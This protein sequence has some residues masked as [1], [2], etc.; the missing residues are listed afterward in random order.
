MVCAFSLSAQEA[1]VDQDLRLWSQV[2]Y[3]ASSEPKESKR[4][5]YGDKFENNKK[6]GASKKAQL[7]KALGRKAWQP[8]LESREPGWRRA[9]TVSCCPLGATHAHGMPVSA[10][11]H[12]V[13]TTVVIMVI[14]VII[15]TV[16]ENIVN[17][18]FSLVFVHSS[19]CFFIHR[20]CQSMVCA[21]H[22]QFIS[23]GTGRLPN[24]RKVLL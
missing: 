11:R 2:I 18:T 20:I 3:K 4:A 16:I 19:I 12:I 7:V 23:H 22:I 9:P 17:Y 10:L 1:P 21:V 8:G 13:H 5:F 14:M 24:S 15:I 6:T